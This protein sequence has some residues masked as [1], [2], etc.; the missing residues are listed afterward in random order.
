MKHSQNGGPYAARTRIGWAING[1]LGRR[2]NRSQCKSTSFLVR[3]DPQFQR[4]VEDFYNRDF[5]DCF[6]DDTTEMSQ[7]ELR[8]MQNA[9]KIQ[10]NDGHY[11]IP[12]Q[13]KDHVVAVPNNKQQA[14]SRITWLKKRLENDPKFHDD[15]S[16]FMKELV[17][18][19]YARKVPL[20]TYLIME[21]TI[22]INRKKSGSFL[23]ARRSLEGFSLNS[24]LY[25]GPDLTNSLV[26]VLTWF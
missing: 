1:P 12:L 17:D 8:F 3:V 4:M 16:A 26:G 21:F 11:Q 19:G 24:M 2:R 18:K 15:Y 9:K 25:K 13:F 20:G 7:D 23:T 10:L 14:L 22:H 5:T 6:V